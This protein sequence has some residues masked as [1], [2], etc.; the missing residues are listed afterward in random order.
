MLIPSGDKK[1]AHSYIQPVI[2][3]RYIFLVFKSPKGFFTRLNQHSEKKKTEITLH[4]L[5]SFESRRITIKSTPKKALNSLTQHFPPPHNTIFKYACSI[6]I[7]KKFLNVIR[8]DY[9]E[10]GIEYYFFNLLLILNS[11]FPFILPISYSVFV[12]VFP[13]TPLFSFICTL[14]SF[15][16]FGLII[17]HVNDT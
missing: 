6:I 2:G 3:N 5:N 13:L 11:G 14:Y 1:L 15:E 9:H 8:L 4:D 16:A 17:R 12:C 7:G 10:G